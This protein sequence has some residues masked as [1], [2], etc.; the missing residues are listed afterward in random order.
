LRVRRARDSGTGA[1]DTSVLT[2]E[3]MI[4]LGLGIAT[5]APVLIGLTVLVCL[6]RTGGATEPRAL[7]QTTRLARAYDSLYVAGTIAAIW[8]I[9]ALKGLVPLQ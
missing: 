2:S 3:N 1:V 8:A 7:P 9:L 6:S 4:G 5:S